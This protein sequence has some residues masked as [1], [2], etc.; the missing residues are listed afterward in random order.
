LITFDIFKSNGQLIHFDNVPDYITATWNIYRLKKSKKM[1]C[2][3]I[4][5]HTLRNSIQN[6]KPFT[7]QWRY[8]YY[9]LLYRKTDLNK[10]V[11]VYVLTKTVYFASIMYN[12][13]VEQKLV[14][15]CRR[16]RRK[17]QKKKNTKKNVGQLYIAVGLYVHTICYLAIENIRTEIYWRGRAKNINNIDPLFSHS[18]PFHSVPK[19]APDARYDCYYHTLYLYSKFFCPTI[20]T[21]TKPFSNWRCFNIFTYRQYVSMLVELGDEHTSEYDKISSKSRLLS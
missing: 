19:S 15:H 12:N 11:K 1:C 18:R 21:S 2:I 13:M 7:T 16:M 14:C 4:W 6:F 17:K 20:L 10:Y 5:Y 9:Y 8:R 3:C